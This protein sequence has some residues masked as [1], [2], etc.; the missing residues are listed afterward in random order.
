MNWID[1]KGFWAVA[2]FD[3][4]AELNNVAA[5]SKNL[6]TCESHADAV[7]KAKE[8]IRAGAARQVVIL[9]VFPDAVCVFELVI[10]PVPEASPQAIDP[11]RPR[12]L[13][14]AP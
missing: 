1:P 8:Y 3:G 10:R 14:L 2:V 4:D 7:T 12:R 9:Q 5:G 11:R 6:I 13:E